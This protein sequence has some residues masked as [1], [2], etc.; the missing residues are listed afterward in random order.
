MNT[1]F[2]QCT[3]VE[4]S[5]SP[6]IR[7]L[8]CWDVTPGWAAEPEAEGT[9][10]LFPYQSRSEDFGQG[11]PTVQCTR[12]P[13][14][15]I[16]ACAFPRASQEICKSNP[17][18]SLLQNSRWQIC[19][20]TI[21][22]CATLAPL[23]QNIPVHSHLLLPISSNSSPALIPTST[24]W[25]SAMSLTMASKSCMHVPCTIC[26]DY[27]CKKALT[28]KAKCYQPLSCT[29]SVLLLD[30]PVNALVES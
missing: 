5:W 10:S 8:T 15:W 26:H 19:R 29:Q 7:A 24:I 13:A 20:H 1:T 12:G 25:D 16:M 3:E 27:L 17:N 2:H 21:P 9:D 11:L 22:S 23:E 30:L 28:G 18:R 14:L 6:H 4:K